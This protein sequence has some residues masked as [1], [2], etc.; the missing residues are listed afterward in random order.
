MEF[1][2][3]SLDEVDNAFSKLVTLKYNEEFI[4]EGKKVFNFGGE[5]W[6]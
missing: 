5:I 6:C 2:S 4:D 3:F 1:S